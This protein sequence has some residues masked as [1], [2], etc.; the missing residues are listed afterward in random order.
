MLDKLNNFETGKSKIRRNIEVENAMQQLQLLQR[1]T[2]AQTDEERLNI[3]KMMDEDLLNIF[4]AQKETP[5][6]IIPKLEMAIKKD[7]YRPRNQSLIWF[8][9]NPDLKNITGEISTFTRGIKV[10]PKNADKLR[11]IFGQTLSNIKNISKQYAEDIIFSLEDDIPKDIIQSALEGNIFSYNVLL[12]TIA[13]DLSKLYTSNT[14]PIR[15]EIEVLPENVQKKTLKGL[16][17]TTK[18]KKTE[19]E[20]HKIIIFL[21][22]IRNILIKNNKAYIKASKEQQKQ[23]VFAEVFAVF[24]HEFGHFIDRTNPNYG[25]LGTQVSKIGHKIYDASTEEKYLSNPTE[26][27]SRSLEKTTFYK[28]IKWLKQNNFNY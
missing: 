28:I 1:Y 9:I 3:L 17:I 15:L 11:N 16:H 18:N 22:N 24:I 21:E 2:K 26:I 7:Q 4:I 6:S 20:T 5:T 12:T 14:N 8:A 10:T 23:I 25:A 13:R 19:I 27:S